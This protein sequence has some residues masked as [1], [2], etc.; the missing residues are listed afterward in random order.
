MLSLHRMAVVLFEN[1]IDNEAE[2]PLNN[3]LTDDDR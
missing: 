2:Y 1:C 3:F